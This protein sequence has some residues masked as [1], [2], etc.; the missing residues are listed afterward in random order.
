MNIC[1][2]M[3]ISLILWSWTLFCL[4]AICISSLD[5]LFRSIREGLL[6]WFSLHIK[7]KVCTDSDLWFWSRPFQP[8]VHH[9]TGLRPYGRR[10]LLERNEFNNNGNGNNWLVYRALLMCLHCASQSHRLYSLSS[11]SSPSSEGPSPHFTD[12][13]TKGS[14][15][16]I[17]LASGGTEI[18][19]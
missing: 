18:D 11:Q 19:Q 10:V 16:V 17:G 7:I 13:D 6:K 2:L 8:Y 9:S 5:F 15:E 14:E 4:L 3:C 1:V 12:R